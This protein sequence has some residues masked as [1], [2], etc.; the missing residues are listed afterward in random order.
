MTFLIRIVE[1]SKHSNIETDRHGLPQ[2]ITRLLD[3]AFAVPE[4]KGARREA[5]RIPF[6]T[7]VGLDSIAFVRS[8][9]EMLGFLGEAFIA[10]VRML[11]GKA[12]FRRL[13]PL[14]P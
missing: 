11:Q 5:V 10:F 12:R 4:R 8:A 9:G 1:H 2:G 7:R 13:R 6:L 3:L 14:Q